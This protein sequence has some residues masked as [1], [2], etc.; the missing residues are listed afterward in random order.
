MAAVRFRWDKN[1]KNTLLFARIFG[2][3]LENKE[4]MM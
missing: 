4:R 2:I 1:L 3:I